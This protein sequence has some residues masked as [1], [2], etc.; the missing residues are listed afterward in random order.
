MTLR[1]VFFWLHLTAGTVAGTVILIMSVTGV[2]LTYERQIIS[3]ADCGYRSAS[4]SPGAARLPVETLL[5]G[6]YDS[7]RA[8][9]ASITLR[10]DPAAPAEAAFGRE[11]TIFIDVYTGEVIGEG[12][13]RVRA[14]FRTVTD[15][16]RWLGAKDES[17]ATARA[18]TGACNLAFLFLVVTGFYLWFPRKWTAQ[19][20]SSVTLF[21]SGLKGKARDFNWHNVI[22][23]WSAIPLFFVVLG[24]LVISYPW[25]TNLVYRLAGSEPPAQKAPARAA[26]DPASP[27]S[28]SNL[29]GVNAAWA[30]AE[31]QV[32]GWR[33]ISLRLPAS[34]GAPLA[35]TID[36]AHRGRPDQRSLLTVDRATGDVIAF[37][38]FSSYS[39]GRQLRTWLRWV[40]TGEA[41]G[42]PG[43][44]I[45]GIASAGG[46][47]LVWTGIALA[48]RRFR[49]SRARKQVREEV[50]V[51]S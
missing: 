16:H 22:G 10:E 13:R 29:D 6:I 35:F 36:K 50:E 46:A 34:D 1:K 42:I 12:S 15:W 45:A 40:H 37:E 48:L 9:P 11:R 21:R 20:I 39:P 4:P 18:I 30:Q 2:L 44:T 7:D 5:G 51:R 32:S 49:A 28:A 19:H 43:Q 47:V 14:F 26:G 38:A 31:R 3:W 25:A 8:L 41:G 27:F 23:F 33:S 24:A 17:R